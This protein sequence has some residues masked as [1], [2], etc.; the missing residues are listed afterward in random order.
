MALEHG[1]DLEFYPQHDFE[2]ILHQK[3]FI[4]MMI[5]SFS[6]FYTLRKATLTTEKRF[7]LDAQRERGVYE[8]L[9]N[10][11]VD[12]VKSKYGIPDLVSKST[13]DL[14]LTETLKF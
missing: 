4:R 6:L 10:N 13:I 7:L 12:S 2:N 5:D 8:Y 11:N 1:F 14:I 9:E 3:S